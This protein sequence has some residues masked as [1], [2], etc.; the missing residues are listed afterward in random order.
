MIPTLQTMPDTTNPWR[1]R[2]QPACLHNH[3]GHLAN[4]HIMRMAVVMPCLR[5]HAETSRGG[6]V[7]P[8]KKCGFQVAEL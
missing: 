2:P 7:Q 4:R 5:N 8:H 1:S 3:G 6:Q